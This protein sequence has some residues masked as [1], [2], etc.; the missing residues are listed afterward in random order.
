MDL[1]WLE[2]E[3]LELINIG[4]SLTNEH[5]IDKLLEKIVS[6]A[7][8][9]THSD[10]GSLYIKEENSLKFVIAQNDTLDKRIGAD[11]SRYS[12]KPFSLPLNKK[13]IAGYVAITGKFIKINDV[14][15]IPSENEYQFNKDFDIRNNYRSKSMLVLPLFDTNDEILGVLQ[16][17]NSLDENNQIIPFD[18]YYE[19]F[20]QCLASQASVAIKNAR[21]AY[22]LKQAHLNTLLRLSVAAEYRDDETGK[23]VHRIFNFTE[24][25]AND[26]N[27][28]KEAVEL[29][30][31]ASLMHD[32]G[33]IAIPDAILLKPGRFTPEERIIMEQHTIIGSKILNDTSSTFL[34][35]AQIVALNH[36]EKFNGTGYPNKLKGNDIPMSGRIVALA[37]VF[38]ALYCKRVYKDAYPIEKVL[39]IIKEEKGKHFDPDIVD[40]FFKN[41]DKIMEMYKKHIE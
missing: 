36:H 33:K 1:K 5:D 26:L 7:R 21:L 32:I 24:I 16:L 3:F 40:V 2:K 4:I 30:K 11:S 13:S 38:D 19:R 25:I 23:H 37:D 6:E 41:F 22:E 17:I 15:E 14:Y 34:T 29:I 10:A 9:F 35:A 27:L 18:Q 31:Y 12:F 8:K 39:D 20:V 28:K